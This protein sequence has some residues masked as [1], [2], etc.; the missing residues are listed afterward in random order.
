MQNSGHPI[1]K[2]TRKKQLEIDPC[3]SRNGSGLSWVKAALETIEI[4]E[5][6]A[7]D[8]NITMVVAA[9]ISSSTLLSY[10]VISLL[11]IIFSF[12]YLIASIHP[13]IFSFFPESVITAAK[14]RKSL[15]N[16]CFSR[17]IGSLVL[18]STVAGCLEELSFVLNLKF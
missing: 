15:K 17:C 10:V 12:E 9:K 6:I 11:T 3:N 7:N 1:G 4:G 14:G 2:K 5:C 8:T 18:S 16:V 13:N